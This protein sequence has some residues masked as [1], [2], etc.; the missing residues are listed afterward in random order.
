MK[1]QKK[2]DFDKV[3]NAHFQQSGVKPSLSQE[4]KASKWYDFTSDVQETPGGQKGKE[5]M[6]KYSSLAESSLPSP[7]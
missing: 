3:H 7:H 6:E 4:Q 1:Q 5:L 2:E